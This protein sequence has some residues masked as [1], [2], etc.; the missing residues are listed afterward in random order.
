MASRGLWH[1]MGART[2]RSLALSWSAL[3]V[4]SLLLQYFTFALAPAALAV[5]DEDLFELDGNA[6]NDAAVTGDDWNSHPGA[7]GNRFTFIDDLYNSSLDIGFAGGGSKD[8]LNTSSWAWLQDTVTPDKDDIEH[9]YAASYVKDGHTFVYF[10]LDK[11]AVNGD[12]NVGFWFFK[13]GIGLTGGPTSGGFAPQHTVGDLLVLSQFTNGGVVST[14]D[15]YEWVG[16][17][18]SNGTLDKI[19]AGNACTGSP[20]VDKACAIANTAPTAAPWAYHPKSGPDNIFPTASFFEGGIDLD[21]LF[22]P[23]K[24]PCFSGFLADTRT[25][26]DVNAVLKDVA[27]GQFNTCVPPTITTDASVSTFHFGDAAVT[28]TAT[29]SGS[30]GPASGK[31]KFFV[32]NPADITAA[33]CPKGSG[34]Q[35]GAAAGVTVTTSTN[36]GSATSA[37]FTPTAAGKYCFRAEYIP[38]AASQYLAAS[39]TNATTECFTVVKNPTA[40]TTAAEQ[41]VNLGQAIADSATLSGATGDAGGSIVFRAYGPA[42]VTCANTPAFVSA[43]FAVSGNG[44]YGAASFIPTT[45][46]TYRWIASYGGDAKN[47]A[48]I[49]SCNDAGENDVVN[50]LIP[51]I[52]T[53]ASADV[54]VGGQIHDTATVSGGQNPTGT[55]T[56]NLYGPNDTSCGS[57]A[58]FTSGP[59]ALSNGSA[60]SGNFTTTQV[61]TYRWRATYNGDVNNNPVTGACNAANENVVVSPASPAITTSLSGDG[62]TGASI[63]VPL[64]TPVHDSSTLSGATATAGGTVHYQVFSDPQCLVLL[65]DAGTKTVVNHIVPNSNDITFIHA[66]TYY[67]QADYSGDPNNNAASSACNL[68][69]VTVD[70]NIPTIVT[71]ASGT[72][73]VGGQ[74]HDSATLSGGFSP[75]G[76]ITFKLYGPND[77]TCTGT[78]A[79]TST[80]TVNNGNDTY[81]SGN[82]T[83]TAAGTYRWVASYSGDGDNA[84]VSGGCNDNNESV[85]VTK[86][87]PTVVTTASASVQVGNAISDSALLAGG[88]QPTGS[89]TFNL[90]GPADNN[91]T[92]AVKFTAT[93]TVSGNGTYGSGNYTATAA[94]TYHWIANYSGDT[95]NNATANGCNEANENVIVTPRN[96]TVVTTASASVEVGG[97]ISDSALLA[98]GFNSTGSIT[99]NLYGPNDLNCT[100]AVKFTAT[101]TV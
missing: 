6:L 54:I 99:F 57:A 47:L 55:V 66:G 51:T 85:V 11:L 22:A 5:H 34:T 40:I 75:T 33:G 19:A 96:P 44:T 29:L 69:T 88:Y 79:F 74:I 28:D 80:V 100:G 42:D 87:N 89:I 68:E 36:G 82:F 92:G 94:G 56:F 95:N 32:C 8:D 53:Q 62:R 10:G 48:S 98:G 3:F 16:S 78:V 73:Q 101:V 60:T 63:T 2:R 39:H 13:N 71:N 15:L 27:V 83:T 67:W 35:V 23:G 43:P 77:A 58:I 37:G 49:G 12:S 45:A 97:V 86:R 84:A 9:A 64:G 61:G 76:S 91:C 24:A 14:I 72:V 7:T 25:S 46:G 18:G 1:F 26:Q 65:S 93:I 50:K 59:I 31:V 70:K 81:A 52:A 4:L 38:D 41:T 30:D 17:G 90:Y 20:A 21:Q